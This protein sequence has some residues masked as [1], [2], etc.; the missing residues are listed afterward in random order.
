MQEGLVLFHLRRPLGA[1]WG[2][3]GGQSTLRGSPWHRGRKAG[4]ASSQQ[5]GPPCPPALESP[6]CKRDNTPAEEGF[7][8]FERG[9]RF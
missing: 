4:A 5:Q 1:R 3:D 9:R 7:L 2:C 8:A 6:T